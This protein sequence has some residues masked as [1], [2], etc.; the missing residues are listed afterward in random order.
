M[1]LVWWK[2]FAISI[3][4]FRL[5]GTY[6]RERV[7]N[8]VED[9]LNIRQ[10]STNTPQTSC[11]N[12]IQCIRYHI[13]RFVFS[14]FSRY[15]FFSTK[16]SP[17]NDFN[18]LKTPRAVFYRFKTNS[19]WKLKRAE[20]GVFPESPLRYICSYVLDSITSFYVAQFLYRTI[21]KR[22][23]RVWTCVASKCCSC[24]SMGLRINFQAT[25]Y[26]ITGA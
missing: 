17:V 7:R 5:E 4:W 12:Y 6:F 11:G 18:G 15:N 19:A 9:F 13:L 26:I 1:V 10:R 2:I 3:V 8:H 20:V 22:T 25:E 21:L 24:V 16:Y 23:R 14:M